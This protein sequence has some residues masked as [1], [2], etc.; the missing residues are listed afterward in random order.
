[1]TDTT[2]LSGVQKAAVLLMQMGK[3]RSAKLLRSMK[4]SEVAMVMAEITRLQQVDAESAD[5][6]LAEARTTVAARAHLASGGYE[7]AKA[8][9]EESLGEEKAISILDRLGMTM[10]E[11]PFEFL[12]RADPR[13]VLSFLQDE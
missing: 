6:V 1:M 10:G 8:L 3:E 12:R 4:E 2:H 5:V 9:L 13:Q 7:T 11:L